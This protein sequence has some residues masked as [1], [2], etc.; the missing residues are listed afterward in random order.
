M[1]H[2]RTRM[3]TSSGPIWG[4]GMSVSS[5]FLYSVRRRA[6]MLAFHH[7]QRV[8]L[9]RMGLNGR[10]KK[11]L[12]LMHDPAVSVDVTPSEHTELYVNRELSLLE[13]QHR[14]LEEAQDPRNP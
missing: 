9:K 12:E 1:P 2:A 5:S 14:V 8:T 10:A 11:K 6:F 7:T 13:F 4:T 3:R